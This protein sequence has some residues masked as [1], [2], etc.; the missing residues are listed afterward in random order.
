MTENQ[1]VPKTEEMNNLKNEIR[2]R[3]AVLIDQQ[4]KR[5]IRDW[6]SISGVVRVYE[7]ESHGAGEYSYR[8]R[9]CI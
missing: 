4:T 3:N 6:Q 5:Q 9:Q 2:Q 1:D 7:V 8:C